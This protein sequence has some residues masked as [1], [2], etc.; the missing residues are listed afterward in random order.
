MNKAE[1]R[2]SSQQSR[3]SKE[4]REKACGKRVQVRK[5]YGFGI[6]PKRAGWEG[7]R[8]GEYETRDEKAVKGSAS[9]HE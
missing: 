9:F 8:T 2:V 6:G 5:G 3:C 4:S 1:I 7:G